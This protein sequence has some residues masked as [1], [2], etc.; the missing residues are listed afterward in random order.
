MAD[1]VQDEVMDKLSQL[2][3]DQLEELAT[4]LK[5]TFGDEKRGKKRAM[6]NVISRYLSSEELEAEEDEGQ[7]VFLH[8]NDVMDVMMGKDVK[9]KVEKGDLTKTQDNEPTPAA[10]TKS[11]LDLKKSFLD[12]LDS[13][14]TQK[15]SKV[16]GASGASQVSFHK[17]REFKINGSV[18]GDAKDKIT[19]DDLLFQM[20]EGE[21]LG[22][23]AREVRLGVIRAMKSGSKLRNYF[24]GQIDMDQETFKSILRYNCESKKAQK[25]MDAMGKC[26]Q[27]DRDEMEFVFDMAQQRDNILAVTK[28]EPW[29]LPVNTVVEKFFHSVSVGF[30][31]VAVRLE[32]RPLLRIMD[33]KTWISD[34]DLF[35]EVRAVMDREKENEEK[36]NDISV[37]AVVNNGA[38]NKLLKEMGRM[39]SKMDEMTKTT[40]AKVE[41]MQNDIDVLKQAIQGNGNI[42]GNW[43]NN[44]NNGNWNQNRNRHSNKGN[45]QHNS[46]QQN[47][48]NF[49]G[50]GNF[51][52]N[53]WNNNNNNMQYNSNFNNSNNF[54]NNF[55]NNNNNFNNNNHNFN[56]N[57]R[58][59]NQ[60]FSNMG[61]LNA[62]ANSFS[63]ATN[64]NMGGVSNSGSGAGNAYSTLTKNNT[65]SGPGRGRGRGRGG[66]PSSN[67][68]N[69]AGRGAA[70]PVGRGAG[71]GMQATGGMQNAIGFLQNHGGG[72]G[73]RRVFRKC[74]VCEVTNAFCTHCWN[75]GGDHK[76]SD[77]PNG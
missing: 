4:G 44:N 31:N 27:G 3:V 67:N 53:S 61:V 35:K 14:S 13:D 50:G 43:N 23:S 20:E 2:D 52:G 37:N 7:A 45:N 29:P 59:Q 39:S 57:F 41:V 16:S 75:C 15:N 32:M 36:T 38:E 22:Y 1:Q 60:N 26:K 19:I 5:L 25:L 11:S 58:N 42:N 28:E 64:G 68:V 18:G 56:G 54:N 76:Y 74:P 21:S 40:S 73:S 51:G 47:N 71:G 77:C 63:P 10:D 30:N 34:A 55:N 24:Q 8:I 69:G 12:S 66:N 49:G 62:A 17:L 9:P 72:P 46:N 6:Y 48:V 70:G 33:N 65:N